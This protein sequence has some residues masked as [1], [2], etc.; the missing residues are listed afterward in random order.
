MTPEDPNYSALERAISEIRSEEIDSAA[1]EAAATRVWSR[2]A[3]QG[4]GEPIRNCAD[5]QALI[6]A[7][8]AG[9]LPE[10]RALLV[11]DHLHQCVACRRV[12][13]GKVTTM[14]PRASARP[15]V[16]PARWA[17]AAGVLLVAGIS[18]WIVIDRFGAHS[19]QAMVQ[20]VS[21]TLYELSAAGMHPMAAGQALPDGVEIRTARDSDALLQLRDGSLVELRERS[22][23]E[24][25]ASGKDTTVHMSHGS[26]IVQAAHRRS[27]HLYVATADCRVAVTGTVFSVSSGVTGSRVSVIAGEVHVA[28]GNSEKVLH[29]GQ[30]TTTT[31]SLAP[32]SVPD[33][34]AWSRDRDHYLKLLQQ[35]SALRSDL[36]QVHLPELRYSS[37]LLARLPAN[38]AFFASVPNLGNYLAQAQTVIQRQLAQN[39]ELR[40]WWSSRGSK[41]DPL[42]ER[43][44][45]ASEYLGDEIILAA[46]PD[47]NGKI[48]GPVFLAGSRRDGFADFLKGQGVPVAVIS[49]SGLLIFGPVPA[50]VDQM[51]AA[52]GEPSGFDK[53]PFYARIADAYR[54]GV[55]LL[56]CADLSRLPAPPAGRPRYFVAGEKEVDGR[57]EARATV[58]FDGPRSGVAAWLA[59]PSP[60]GVLDYVS[61]QAGFAAS[62]VVKDPV[63]IMDELAH[64]QSSSAIEKALA[65]MRQETGV[66]V[67]NDLAGSLGGEF[68]IALDGPA[69][70]VPSWKLVAEIYNAAGLEAAL[71]KLVEAC[72]L[73]AARQGAKPLRTSQE[74]AGGR[75]YYMIAA[76]DPNPL[77]EVHYTFADGYLIAAP[78]RALLDQALQVKASGA[79]LTRSG[80]FISMLPRDQHVNFSALLYQNLGTTLAPLTGLLGS[81]SSSGKHNDLQSLGDLKPTLITGYCEPD[82]ITLS[83][84]GSLPGLTSLLRGNLGAAGKQFSIGQLFGTQAAHPA[85]R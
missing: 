27:G 17:I 59:P 39:Q 23:F 35:V 19:G 43:L 9:H 15:R 2:V 64:L 62:F 21:G 65:V 11:T 5:F 25:S 4:D 33:D 75:T 44:R 72:N 1:M 46:V 85:Y 42:L 66:D 24:T 47:A 61:P 10:A 57:M 77:T 51:S 20:M 28:Q 3:A 34:I 18:A 12:F 8:K 52:L 69:F 83:G 6:P 76:A 79:A 54:E 38:T 71:Q 50:A 84:T 45:A 73:Q 30:Q 68:A 55:G 78:T 31:A 22:G 32:V 41:I 53:T 14:A 58:S 26:I 29:P 56:L 70:P 74:T 63:A 16:L 37:R 81:F 40:Q 13:E 36:D 7:Y 49:R 82:R 60:M 80:A 48:Q 67:R